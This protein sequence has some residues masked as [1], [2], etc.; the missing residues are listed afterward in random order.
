MPPALA[1]E[2]KLVCYVMALAKIACF[3]AKANLLFIHLPPALAGGNS[4]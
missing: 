1:G 2:I 3:L 4:K